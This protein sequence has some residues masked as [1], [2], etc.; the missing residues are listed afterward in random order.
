METSKNNSNF[1]T[2]NSINGWVPRQILQQFL[3]LKNTSMC[4]FAKKHGVKTSK[5][6]R[7]TFYSLADIENLI[8]NNVNNN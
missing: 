5:I 4:L 6:G 1:L 8:N 7:I 3:G 2:S